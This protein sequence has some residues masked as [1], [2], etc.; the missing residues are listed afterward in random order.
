MKICRNCNLEK[1][2]K[3]FYKTK[4]TSYSD[5]MLNQCKSCIKEYRKQRRI[6]VEKPSFTIEKKEITYS[7]D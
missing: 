7:F 3:E 5:S 1:E 6:L 4:S 2:D